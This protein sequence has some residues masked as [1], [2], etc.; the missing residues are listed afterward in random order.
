MELRR[1]HELRVEVAE[2]GRGDRRRLLEPVQPGVELLRVRHLPGPS[3]GPAT[4][5]D[6]IA[7][8]TNDATAS[9]IPNRLPIMCDS[10]FGRTR[11]PPADTGDPLTSA[12]VRSA[13]IG[14]RS[15]R[16]AERMSARTGYLRYSGRARV[17]CLWPGEP[18][19]VQVLRQLRG[20]A[21][22][23]RCAAGSAQDGD[24]RLLRRDRVDGARRATR[25][26][27]DA[28]HDGPLLRGDPADR[29]A[30][31]R[32]GGEV[33]RRRGDGGVRHPGRARGRRAAGGARGGG[34][35]RA[36]RS[37]SARSCR[38][39]SRFARA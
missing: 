6:P 10:P 37:G 27:G 15:R 38:W 11:D 31:R 21:H 14:L 22:S 20:R 1:S 7:N 35:P 19:R 39:R 4:A 13:A 17:P 23:G 8:S 29:G 34:D 32:H 2:A 28:S 24:G 36:A 26:R 25:S 30:A 3:R 33:H 18:R 12:Y 9:E 5:Y 16:R